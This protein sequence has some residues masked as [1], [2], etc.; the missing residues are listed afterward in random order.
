[1]KKSDSPRLYRVLLAAKDLRH[2]QRFFESLLATRGRSV[3]G[4]RVYFDCGSVL[5]GILDYSPTKD[6]TIS[7]PAEALYFATGDLRGVHRRARKLGCLSTGLLHDDPS[8]PLGEI[9]VRPWGER[10]FYAVDP[11]GNSL[12][13]V[14]ERTLFTGTPA[15]VAASSRGMV[16]D[17]PGRPPRRSLR[18]SPTTRMARSARKA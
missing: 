2:S 8:S 18:S 12:C 6:A 11:S 10:S 4:G 17:A 1:M 7:A 15:Q 13:F 5:L 9:S 14:D 16:R 3:G